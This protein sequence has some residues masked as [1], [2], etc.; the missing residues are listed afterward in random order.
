MDY[1]TFQQLPLAREVKSMSFALQMYS[2]VGP[3]QTCRNLIREIPISNLTTD[4]VISCVLS[5]LSKS[6][7]P[8]DKTKIANM[9]ELY[10]NKPA[11]S[12][13][14]LLKKLL[15]HFQKGASFSGR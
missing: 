4:D 9:L 15:E 14:P 11:K 1:K 12:T 2:L 7:T 6:R 8:I 5:S 3:E 10:R 13:I